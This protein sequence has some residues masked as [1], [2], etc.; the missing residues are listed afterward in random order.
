MSAKSA[1]EIL[2]CAAYSVLFIF[3]SCLLITWK[4][5]TSFPAFWDAAQFLS[6]E[7]TSSKEDDTLSMLAEEATAFKKSGLSLQQSLI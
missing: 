1:L 4:R 6:V 3:F 2:P 7:W 5:K